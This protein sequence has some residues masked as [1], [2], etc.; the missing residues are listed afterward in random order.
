MAK[1]KKKKTTLLLLVVVL[2]ILAVVYGVV[3]LG[4]SDEPIE[5]QGP[6]VIPVLEV[7][8]ER[9]A[10]LSYTLNGETLS[11]TNTGEKGWIYD[12]DPSFPL[13]SRDFGNILSYACSV[14]AERAL[15]DQTDK[16]KDFGLDPPEQTITLTMNDGQS[17][18]YY[19][20]KFNSTT[21]GYYLM[22]EGSDV[23][24][25][26]KKAYGTYF[27]MSLMDLSN[28]QEITPV[29]LS[30]LNTMY[31][32]NE[33]GE[34]MLRYKEDGD[35]VAYSSDF[36]WFFEEPDGLVPADNAACEDLFYAL[37]EN[38]YMEKSAVEAV[39]EEELA[40]YGLDDPFIE[41]TID[42]VIATYE[43][44]D[45]ENEVW[46]YIYTP[47]VYTIYV[48]DETEDG[49]YRYGKLADSPKVSLMR[50]GWMTDVMAAKKSDLRVADACLIPMVTVE[51]MD[52]VV[53]GKKYDVD[54][55]Q[56]MIGSGDDA[57]EGAYEV[58]DREV[59]P[60]AFVNFYSAVHDLRAEQFLDAPEQPA[61][62]PYVTIKIERAVGEDVTLK[63][64]PYNLNFYLASLN[65]EP[66]YQLVSIRDVEKIVSRLEAL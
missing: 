51:E 45:E 33:H 40:Q 13:N 64:T 9:V 41:V 52:I 4:G 59:A 7:D 11:F 28:V 23:V 24:Y 42:H 20:G 26:V 57:I 1:A 31:L 2:V 35:P 29:Y 15:E 62:D 38:L 27:G 12:A 43:C 14:E 53:D 56:H 8:K 66:G 44:V 22:R 16:L 50:V 32:K 60:F 65:D 63:L 49:V 17:F 54:I 6:T 3:M 46:K 30:G 55:K 47:D 21:N 10:A 61:A 39:T 48:G 58:N 5:E 25:S 37:T 19:L 36:H 34:V 18:V